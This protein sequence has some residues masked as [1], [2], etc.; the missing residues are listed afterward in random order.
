MTFKVRALFVW[1]ILLAISRAA[2]TTRYVDVNSASP[3][4]SYTNWDA[5]ARTIQDAINIADG[6]DLILVTNGIYNSGGA[7]DALTLGQ[8]RV[9][10]TKALTLR[11]VNGPAVTI[12]DAGSVGT[13]YWRCVFLTSGATLAGF[14]LTNGRVFSGSGVYCADHSA[15]VS[16]C[17]LSGNFGYYGTGAAYGG[18]LNNCVLAGN[19]G[20]AAIFANLNNCTLTGNSG[21]GAGGGQ[22]NNCVLSAN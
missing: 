4:P 20:T 15:V 7:T 16:N 22:L 19:K 14:A 1:L 6:G 11:S 10:V 2:P 8:N 17:V 13:N 9:A 21:G 5:A 3:A 12:I 18:T